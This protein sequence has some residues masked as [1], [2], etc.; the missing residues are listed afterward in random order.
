MNTLTRTF[1]F[2]G[3]TL[4]EYARSGR[5][6]I[7]LIAGV[8][9]FYIFLRRWTSLPSPEYFFSTT[10]LFMLTL[11][12][13]STSA[14]LG[15]GDRPQGYLLLVR[16]LGRGGYLLG[17]YLA[18]QVIVWAIYGLISI[19][20]ALYNPIQGLDVRGWLLGSLPLLL[21]ATLL[22]ALLTLLAPIVLPSTGR[23][24][25][26]ALVAI[27]FSGGLIGGQTLSELPSPSHGGDQYRANDLQHP[28]AAGIYRLCA[29][30]QPRLRRYRLRHPTRAAV[31][32]ARIAD[33]G[34]LYLRT[35][36]NYPQR[37]LTPGLSN[38][39]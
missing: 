15:L 24:V 2:V 10:G 37:R 6:L 16:R 14:A 26:L 28:A 39:D 4:V 35:A 22:G 31:P 20:M 27:A 21:N 36:R 32:H 17:F 25:V 3:F 29:F 34:G 18:A 12:F 30:D 5:I 9:F 19:A 7:E 11:T 38:E 23:L 8:I 33:N 1:R 13:Y